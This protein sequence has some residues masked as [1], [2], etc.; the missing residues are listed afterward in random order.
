MA[1]ELNNRISE[2]I[3]FVQTIMRFNSM[4]QGDAQIYLYRQKQTKPKM[5][6]VFP[7]QKYSIAFNL[8]IKKM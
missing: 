2:I 1:T 8:T 7:S 6:Q 5:N 4:C 3:K